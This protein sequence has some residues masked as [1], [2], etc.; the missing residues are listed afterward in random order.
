MTSC[1]TVTAL[2]VTIRLRIK[3]RSRARSALVALL[4]L[5]LGWSQDWHVTRLCV[6]DVSNL[7]C[8]RYQT[9][10]VISFTWTLMDVKLCSMLNVCNL[11]CRCL[12]MYDLG[13]MLV[14]SRSFD[15]SSYYRVYMGW[16]PLA[17]LLSWSLIHLNSYKLDGS[18]TWFLLC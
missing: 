8:F 7:L 5:L 10:V 15:V 14:E 2:T 4:L 1:I 11:W 6:C 17:W 18:V 12:I 3:S 13:C 9:G 16:S